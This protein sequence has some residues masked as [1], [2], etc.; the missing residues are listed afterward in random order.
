M[1]TLT[2]CPFLTVPDVA[3]E[4]RVDRGTVYRLIRS[5]RLPHVRFGTGIDA[6]RQIFGIRAAD[7]ERFIAEREMKSCPAQ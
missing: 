6:K 3:A 1:A 7:L 4:L 5:G 2:R